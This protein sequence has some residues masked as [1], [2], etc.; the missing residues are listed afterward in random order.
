MKSKRKQNKKRYEIIGLVLVIA[1]IVGIFIFAA[2]PSPAGLG[3][4]ADEISGLPWQAV[5]N[6]ISYSGGKVGI[7]GITGEVLS[8]YGSDEPIH[9]VMSGDQVISSNAF[10]ENNLWN[11]AVA[12]SPAYQLYFGSQDFKIRVKPSG[13]GT[14][15]EGDWI[16]ALTI[17]PEGDVSIG[18]LC[19]EGICQS[20]WG[21]QTETDPQVGTLTSGKW[22]KSDGTDINCIFD[23]PPVTNGIAWAKMFKEIGFSLD[24]WEYGDGDDCKVKIINTITP[25]LDDLLPANQEVFDVTIRACQSGLHSVSTTNLYDQ[26]FSDLNDLEVF[27]RSDWDGGNN[28]ITAVAVTLKPHDMRT[29]YPSEL[30]FGS[31][32]DKCLVIHN[33]GSYLNCGLWTIVEGNCPPPGSNYFGCHT[34]W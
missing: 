32:A 12:N 30:A 33:D 10:F 4:T 31:L 16:E 26:D 29:D 14:F 8:L 9:F 18:S 17:S 19:L 5:A 23:A 7:G 6:G 15:S 3:H 2:D 21:A 25:D 27:A 24:I 20:S 13:S 28:L 34:G 1:V 11:Y 22:C